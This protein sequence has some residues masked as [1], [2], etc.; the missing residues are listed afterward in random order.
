MTGRF[1]ISKVVRIEREDNPNTISRKWVDYSL[2]TL[3]KLYDQGHKDTVDRLIE[4]ELMKDVDSLQ[5]QS[6]VREELGALLTDLTKVR[7]H[8]LEYYYGNMR[9]KLSGFIDKVIILN[10]TG[11][12]NN[13]EANQIGIRATALKSSFED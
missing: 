3:Q 13:T 5:S 12:I 11:K 6:D 4:Q 7:G 9:S 1:R 10:R 8:N 2:T